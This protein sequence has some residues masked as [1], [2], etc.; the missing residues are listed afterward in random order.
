MGAGV[1]DQIGNDAQLA[2]PACTFLNHPSLR[3]CEICGSALPR[4]TLGGPSASG[5]SRTN[6][7]APSSRPP[8]PGGT[9]ENVLKVSFRRGGDKAFYA[10]LKNALEMKVWGVVEPPIIAKNRTG[11]RAFLFLLLT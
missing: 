2:C 6:K 1:E 4:R 11:I 5:T 7:S 3:N 10:A 8:S 9:R